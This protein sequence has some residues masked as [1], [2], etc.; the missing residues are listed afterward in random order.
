MLGQDP[1][2]REHRQRT[3]RPGAGEFGQQFG[4][5]PARQR[6]PG[7]GGQLAGQRDDRGPSQL[8]DPPR[9]ARAGQVSQPGEPAAG[10]PA[11]PLAHRIHGDP[12]VHGDPGVI[13]APGRRQHDLG[14]QPVPV[15]G[16]RAGTVV[17]RHALSGGQRDRHRTGQRHDSSRESQIRNTAPGHVIITRPDA[18]ARHNEAHARH[19]AIHPQLHHLAAAGP[20]RKELAPAGQSPGQIPRLLRLT[21]PASCPAASRSRCSGSATAARPTPSAPRSTHPPATATKTPPCSPGCPS[22]ARKK[23]STP[24]APSTSQ[25]LDTSPNPDRDELTVSPTKA[26][27]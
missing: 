21:S 19:P 17:Q 8:A 3:V 10:E 9:P 15:R 11:P 20:R 22:A 13:P 12:Q 24:P 16:L 4:P 1:Q 14:P 25:R 26:C 23:H 6:H 7:R 18:C 2:H 5:G 27:R